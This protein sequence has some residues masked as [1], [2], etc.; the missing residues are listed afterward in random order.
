MEPP[1]PEAD[2]QGPGPIGVRIGLGKAQLTHEHCHTMALEARVASEHDLPRLMVALPGSM[3][4]GWGGGG[5]HCPSAGAPSYGRV[6]FW[7]LRWGP[8]K[9]VLYNDIPVLTLVRVRCVW[10]LW[11]CQQQRKIKRMHCRVG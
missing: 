8:G 2:E 9:L 6:R 5:F 7:R 4:R 3:P 10:E 1:R 11:K